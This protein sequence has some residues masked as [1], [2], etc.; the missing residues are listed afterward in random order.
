VGW[1]RPPGPRELDR[2]THASAKASSGD[3][4]AVIPGSP[5]WLSAASKASLL[6]RGRRAAPLYDRLRSGGEF[7]AG[8]D[9][10]RARGFFRG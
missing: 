6:R 7:A 8:A 1:C 9:G 10:R 2:W 3:G 5:R 4:G